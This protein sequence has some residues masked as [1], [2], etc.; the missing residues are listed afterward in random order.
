MEV[1][2]LFINHFGCLLSDD[3]L[4]ILLKINAGVRF[5]PAKLTEACLDRIV[6]TPYRALQFL[7]VFELLQVVANE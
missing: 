4:V 2:V 1:M 3:C 7:I 5:V 6:G